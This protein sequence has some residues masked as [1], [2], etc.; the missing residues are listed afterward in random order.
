MKGIVSVT[1]NQG[2]EGEHA[3]RK[4]HLLSWVVLND[5][6]AGCNTVCS[7]KLPASWLFELVRVKCIHLGKLSRLTNFLASVLAAEN[8]A[9]GQNKA[10]N[11][12][13]FPM[14]TSQQD[15]WDWR[16]SLASCVQAS[17]WVEFAAYHLRIPAVLPLSVASI[18]K[19]AF[20]RHVLQIA[21]PHSW[22][23]HAPIALKNNLSLHQLVDT[24]I[25]SK[26]CKRALKKPSF[27]WSAWQICACSPTCCKPHH[28]KLCVQK[29]CTPLLEFCRW[30][31]N[32]FWRVQTITEEQM[33]W[34]LSGGPYTTL[35]GFD[36]FGRV[37][38]PDAAWFAG[39]CPLRLGHNRFHRH[40]ED[41][42]YVLVPFFEEGLW[43][44]RMMLAASRGT[45]GFS[46]FCRRHVVPV[47]AFSSAPVAWLDERFKSCQPGL[48]LDRRKFQSLQMIICTSAIP[49]EWCQAAYKGF[50][51][52]EQVDHVCSTILN[53]AI[54]VLYS[55][56]E[57]QE[58]S[59]RFHLHRPRRPGGTRQAGWPDFAAWLEG[60]QLSKM[61]QKKLWGLQCLNLFGK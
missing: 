55:T 56:F 31:A 45:P 41:Y 29:K 44:I 61:T 14:D 8:L 37:A 7:H 18:T 39:L 17:V 30:Y 16:L 21:K 43:S 34:T 42:R 40:I 59:S 20:W 52:T 15:W 54:C 4:A 23:L 26:E 1:C 49:C 6:W 25:A 51:G 36:E 33:G 3:A 27:G 46:D 11:V 38:V 2:K 57:L 48:W 32:S 13:F 22:Q 9:W 5:R 24:W 28:L 60:W 19:N 53:M 47:V 58:A 10:S 50:Q 35:G 12:I